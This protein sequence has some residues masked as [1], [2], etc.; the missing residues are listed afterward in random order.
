[1]KYYIIIILLLIIL[2]IITG[3]YVKENFTIMNGKLN[4][5]KYDNLSIQKYNNSV[6][7]CQD[8]ICNSKFNYRKKDQNCYF[9]NNNEIHWNSDDSNCKE[10]ILQNQKKSKFPDFFYSGKCDPITT[11]TTTTTL[12]PCTTTMK[13][14]NKL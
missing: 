6:N 5:K 4:K 11:T 9:V 1:M 3:L 14:I 13:T 2:F 12:P 8:L 7:K 10:W